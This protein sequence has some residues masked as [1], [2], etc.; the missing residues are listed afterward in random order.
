MFGKCWKLIEP[1]E[2]E[3]ASQMA[4]SMPFLWG[5][6]KLVNW[7]IAGKFQYCSQDIFRPSAVN[8]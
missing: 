4:G 5:R 2:E 7:I 1:I 6:I 3:N 8:Q